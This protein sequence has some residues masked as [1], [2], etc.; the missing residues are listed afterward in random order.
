MK[1]L[2]LFLL[3][4]MSYAQELSAVTVYSVILPNMQGHIL[5]RGINFDGG[6]SPWQPTHQRSAY[7]FDQ[8]MEN[9]LQIQTVEGVSKIWVVDHQVACSGGCSYLGTA[10]LPVDWTEHKWIKG[11]SFYVV[12]WFY[13]TLVDDRGTHDN[14]ES[15]VYFWTYPDVDG[16]LFPGPGGFIAELSP[17]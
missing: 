2:L 9:G 16:V 12:G 7:H 14:V 10:E 11:A 8:N 3:A 17:N 15:V 6:D 5:Q 4:G 13:G 1:W